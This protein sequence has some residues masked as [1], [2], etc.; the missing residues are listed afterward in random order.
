MYMTRLHVHIDTHVTLI[1]LAVQISTSEAAK[2]QDAALGD[3]VV[4]YL[5]SAIGP[6]T[7]TAP[8]PR[9]SLTEVFKVRAARQ[10]RLPARPRSRVLEGTWI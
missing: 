3:D 5:R 2:W 8:T 7:A 9:S 1:I 10:A 4:F 6:E